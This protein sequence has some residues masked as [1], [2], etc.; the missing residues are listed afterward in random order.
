MSQPSTD[1]QATTSAVL[2]S[3][4]T[5]ADTYERRIGRATRAVAAHIIAKTL[6]DLPERSLI[7]DNACGTGAVTDE[8][9]KIYPGAHIEATDAAPPMV[10]IV[11]AQMQSRGLSNQVQ[12]S[13]MDGAELMFSDDKFNASVTNFGIFFL[14][15]PLKGMKEIHRTLKPGGIAVLTCWERLNL[16]YEIFVGIEKLIKPGTEFKRPDFLLKW[17]DSA[18]MEGLLKEAGFRD[19]EMENV[20]VLLWGNDVDDLAASI[21]ENMRGFIGEEYTVGEKD[22]CIPCAKAYLE[23]QGK[24]LLIHEADKVGFEMSAWVAKVRK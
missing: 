3:F 11:K 13:V 2:S 24:A 22:R 15:E 10:D 6:G 17:Q 16:I 14:P 20:K 8:L 9:L 18:T 5:S 1:D 23:N 19:V 7:H 4:A 12:G 21:G